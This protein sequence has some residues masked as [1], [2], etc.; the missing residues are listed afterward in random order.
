MINKIKVFICFQK[1]DR[2]EAKIIADYL[3]SVE[4]PV[5]LGEL[6]NELDNELDKTNINNDPKAIIT[7]IKKGI[8]SSTHM[9]CILS[10]N[11]LTSKWVPFEIGYGYDV[12]DLAILTL[13]GIK[14]SEL[15]DYIKTK[16]II[17]DIY[18]VNKFVIKQGKG[19]ILE[20]KMFSEYSSIIHPL[21]EIMDTVIT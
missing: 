5:Y 9:F 13:K 6:D 7:G 18:D 4:I 16:P 14:N 17:R 11:S 19:H 12:T 15:P 10:P 21:Y 8:N 2:D 20:S 3:L 1:Q